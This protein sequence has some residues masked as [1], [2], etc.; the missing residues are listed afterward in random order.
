MNKLN[1]VIAL[2]L[3]IQNVMIQNIESCKS[4][5]LSPNS[6]SQRSYDASC[7]QNID[8]GTGLMCSAGKCRCAYGAWSSYN[9]A[10]CKPFL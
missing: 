4:T 7:T 3:V 10:C 1:L 9:T 2:F 6:G 8:C 5:S